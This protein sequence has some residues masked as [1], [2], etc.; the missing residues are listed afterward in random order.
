MSRT[1]TIGLGHLYLEKVETLAF[2]SSFADLNVGRVLSGA[3]R[4]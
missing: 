4:R 2:E 1:R 3:A